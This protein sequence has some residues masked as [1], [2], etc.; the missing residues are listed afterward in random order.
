MLRK[1]GNF[2]NRFGVILLMFFCSVGIWSCATVG[3][4]FNFKGPESI[5][6]G[7]TTKEEILKQYGEPFRVGYDDGELKWTYGFYK[8]RLFGSSDTKDLDLTFDKSGYVKN[9]TYAT[10]LDEEKKDLLKN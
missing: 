2:M 9:Y 10:S 3:N 8:Y 7:K 4:S 1:K 5:V 6:I